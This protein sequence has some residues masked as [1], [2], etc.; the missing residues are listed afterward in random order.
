MERAMRAMMMR[1]K[2]IR[3]GG[4]VRKSEDI[5]RDRLTHP[6]HGFATHASR[7]HGLKTRATG[8]VETIWMK[9]SFWFTFPLRGATVRVLSATVI[10]TV[11]PIQGCFA[12]VVP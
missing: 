5:G 12:L 1:L 4:R 2:L 9:L 7:S 3:R 6:W 11:F 8:Q 10:W